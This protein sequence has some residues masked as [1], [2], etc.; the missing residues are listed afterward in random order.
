MARENFTAGRIAAFTC[1]PGKQQA[2][3]WDARAPGLALRVTAGGARAF[4]FQSRLQNGAAVR[5]TIGEPRREDG[6]GT[7][8]IAQ[9]QAEARRLQ[10]LLDQGQDPR[11]ERAATVERHAAE[12]RAAKVERAKRDVTGIDAWQV[13]CEDRRERWGARNYSDHLAMTSAGG[14][15]RKRSREKLTQPGPLRALLAGP[16]AEIDTE[17]VEQ[18]VARETRTRPTRAALGFRLLRAFINWCGEH[19]DYRDIVQ[20]DAC[21]GRRTRE[22]LAK[23]VAK[24]DALQ[25][26][27]LKDWFAAVRGLAPVQAAYLQALLVT[28]ARREEL[29]GLRWEDIDFKWKSMRIRDKVEGERVIP[30]TRHVS[31][32]LLDLRARNERPPAVSRRVR[33]DPEA[34]DQIHRN[35]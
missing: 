22:K 11:V 21:K 7:W 32:L 23:P 19:P 10:A 29:A 5:V 16:L 26:E 17:A 28:G 14:E 20:V 24:D 6:G 31:A 30:L 2:F 27:Q 4:V 35:W 25:R 15:E 3:L 12:R 1:P 9:A 33:G 34:A 18:W 8:T 13:Y